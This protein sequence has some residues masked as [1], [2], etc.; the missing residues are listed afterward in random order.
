[1]FNLYYLKQGE[2]FWKGNRTP[3][4]LT[5]PTMRTSGDE[6]RMI[7]VLMS[8][9][10]FNTLAYRATKHGMMSRNI[11]SKDVSQN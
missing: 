2:A 11:T 8:D 5:P 3:V 1:M 10:V 9:Y 7:T 6:T 4:P